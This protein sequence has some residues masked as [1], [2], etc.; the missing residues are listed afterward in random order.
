VFTGLTGLAWGFAS[1]LVFRFL[2]GLAEAGAFPSCARAIYMWL[3]A[4]E[5]ALAQGINLSG[6]R[7]GAAFALPVIAWFLTF[8]GWRWSFLMLGVIGVLW[9]AAWWLWFRDAPEDHRSVSAAELEHIQAGRGT[10]GA[11]VEPPPVSALLRSSNLWLVMGQYFAS[12]FTFFFCLTWLFPYL[13][14]TYDLDPVQTGLYSAIPL[15]GGAAGNWV[16]GTIVDSL[17]RQ[18]RTGASRR[19]T[20]AVGFLLAAGGLAGSMFAGSAPVA[21]ACLTVAMFGADMTLPPSWA[22]CIDIGGR[23]SGAVSGMMNMAGNIGS[24]VTGL[25]FPYLMAAFGSTHP[26][27]ITGIVL[28]LLA[29]LFWLRMRPEAGLGPH[30]AVQA[31]PAAQ[32]QGTA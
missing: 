9:A 15:L 1:L 4:G 25:A 17:Y 10:P 29:V 5:R 24:F 19:M 16:G 12:N 21:V 23:Y 22:F 27:F 14:R 8:A 28:N 18:G 30:V 26:F 32:P 7:I 11:P 3:P 31:H 20:A 6:S 2:F 13:Q